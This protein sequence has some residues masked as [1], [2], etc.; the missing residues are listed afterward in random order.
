MKIVSLNLSKPV[1]LCGTQTKI[2]L[3]AANFHNRKI[4][5]FYFYIFIMF[6]I[7]VCMFY[8][9]IKYGTH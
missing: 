2:N 1:F 6:K 3:Y 5:S 7:H 9:Y 8:V 4:N